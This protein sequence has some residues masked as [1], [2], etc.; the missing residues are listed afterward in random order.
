MSPPGPK[1]LSLRLWVTSDIGFVW[2]MNW[3]SWLVPKNSFT[4]ADTG[5]ELIRSWGMSVSTSCRLILSL[6]ALSMRTRPM[7]YWFSRSSPTALTLR[8]PRL[9]MSSTMASELLSRMSS[10]TVSMMSSFLR[11]LRSRGT[12]TA[13]R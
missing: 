5:L 11:V 9:S 7:R 6:I 12:S 3:E 10:L 2:S 4:T 13:S 1:A 8:F